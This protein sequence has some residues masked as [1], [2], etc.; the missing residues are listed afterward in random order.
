MCD[1]L[2]IW[3]RCGGGKGC[4]VS[5]GSSSVLDR[6]SLSFLLVISGEKSGLIN[7]H[8]WAFEERSKLETGIL[9]SQANPLSSFHLR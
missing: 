5:T 4:E 7:M 8:T 9:E 2:L 3:R 1:D 6:I